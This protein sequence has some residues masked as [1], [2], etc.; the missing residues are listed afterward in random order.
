M[1]TLYIDRKDCHIKVDGNALAFYVNGKREGIVPLEP[2]KRVIFI[3]NLTLDTSVLKR[4]SD[5]GIKAIFLSGRR[6]RFCGML[7]GSLHNNGLLRLRQYEKAKT[8]FSRLIASE[9]VKRKIRS[10]IDVLTEALKSRHDLRFYLSNAID[11]L[12]KILERLNSSFTKESLKGI[13]GSAS[14]IYFNVYTGLFPDS[15]NFNRRTR[16]PPLDPVNAILSLCY[17]LLHFEIVREIEVIGLDPVI[18]FYHE[19]DYGRESLACDIVE[20]FRADVDRFVWNLFRTREF[21]GDDFSTDNKNGGCYLKKEKRKRFYPLYE[22]WARGIRPLLT[23][24]VREMARRIND[25]EDPLPE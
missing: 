22:E 1:G 10:Q 8:D 18:G 19:F 4:F 16:R 7:Q 6:L 20:I 24:E 21:S 2:L 15:L 17:T 5:L 23:E 12:N 9:I 13:E 11:S 3:G 25:G 14:A